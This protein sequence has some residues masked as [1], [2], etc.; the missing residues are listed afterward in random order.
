MSGRL[1]DDYVSTCIDEE[2]QKQDLTRWIVTL[3]DSTVVYQDDVGQ[4][5]LRPGT[6]LT[7]W[8]RLI[9][10]CKN[11]NNYIVGMQLKFRSHM[12]NMPS[13]AEG[14]FFRRTILGGIGVMR[15]FRVIP[16]TFFYLVGT[17]KDGQVTI[18]KWRVPELVL[19]T[20]E[21]DIRDPHNFDHCG[22]SLIRKDDVTV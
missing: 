3:D 10:Y 13:N 12:E 11:N 4:G 7:S 22:K 6:D 21:E 9:N 19:N 14:Y 16:D 17:L 2:M 5:D 15:T 18:Q 20:E 8:E 1:A